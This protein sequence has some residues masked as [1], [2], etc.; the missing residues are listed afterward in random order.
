[1]SEQL[2]Q[3][4]FDNTPVGLVL[5]NKD[6]TLRD[7]NH[8]MFNAFQ[9][10]QQTITGLRFGNVFNC[11]AVKQHGDICGETDICETCELRGGVMA[12]LQDGV[13]IPE[14]V[15]DHSFFINGTEQ[16]KW[17]KVSA[18]RIAFDSND[19]AIVSFSDITTQKEYEA[20]LNYQ[21]SLD[22]ATGVTNKYNLLN[23]LKT[24]AAG[25]DWLT[26]ALIDFDDFKKINDTYGHLVGDQVLQNFCT[27]ASSTTRRQDIL[28]R[29]GGEEFML[30]FPG[31]Y[32][33]LMVSKLKTIAETLGI[34]CNKELGIS[35][36]FSVGL[37]EFSP[38]ELANIDV[39]KL[40]TYVDA[41]LYE[42]KKRGKNRI[43][44]GDISIPFK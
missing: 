4:V 19:Y 11:V 27:I 7:V 17:F 37:T 44:I 24:F 36:T 42:A 26:I 3:A 1:M 38:E 31:A 6:T 12:V 18:S 23:S 2:L 35:P 34:L 9:M 25:M 10:P 40:I 39:S 14:T 13:T 32:A 20:L 41:N 43:F 33:G 21:L 15:M 8:Y 29:F 5:V 28:G 16:K 30:I 22:M